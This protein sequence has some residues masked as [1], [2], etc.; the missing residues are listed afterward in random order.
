MAEASTLG[1]S[2]PGRACIHP[3]P[4]CEAMGVKAILATIFAMATGAH[5]TER[6]SLLD[7][8]ETGRVT[9]W[10]PVHDRVMGGVSNGSAL[11][12]ELGIRFFG[13]LSL[14]NNGGFAS[15]RREVA[16]PDLSAW[17]G[18]VLR[19]RGDGKT[20]KLGLRIEDERALRSGRATDWQ[21]SFT[22]QAGEWLEIELAFAD[23]VP[24][25][26]GRLVVDAPPFDPSAVR[27]L[28]FLIADEQAGEFGLELAT[29]EAWR[30]TGDA[31]GSRGAAR[32][33]SR[34]LA[35]A[36]DAAPDAPSLAQALRG[37]ERVLVVASPLG[38]DA[39]SS[40][41]LGRFHA[42]GP[43]LAERELRLVR[44]VGDEAGRIAGRTIDGRRVRDLRS[45]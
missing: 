6:L 41:Q 29:L 25:W 36:I 23:L 26:R 12:A 31:P 19:V 20:D 18:L 22:T 8:E 2:V 35:R 28:G 4:A 11:P 43:A 14:E 27:E 24:T 21:A 13:R 44:L 42:A 7:P 16:W 1:L 34:G 32:E 39:R 15:F 5:P 38:L 9:A 33:R 17:D 40:R 45:R 3:A 30:A 10:R 37:S